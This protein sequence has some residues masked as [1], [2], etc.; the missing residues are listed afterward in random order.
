V[1]EP[2]STPDSTPSPL[3]PS[4]S[5]TYT[6]IQEEPSSFTDDRVE[7]IRGLEPGEV[8]GFLTVPK[9]DIW[10][11]P[12]RFGVGMANL[13]RG[14]S[15]YPGAAEPG[16]G[17][18][19]I[20]GHR[21]TPVGPWRTCSTGEWGSEDCHGPFRYLD[22]LE[23]GDTARVIYKGKTYHYEYADT[24][25]VDPSNISI[26]KDHRADMTFTACH[27]PGYSTKRIVAQWELVDG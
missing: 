16:E 10:R 26:L 27:P 22:T 1:F 25:I 5:V 3:K 6:V 14:P 9:L 4:S 18:F 24:L 7:R 2:D 12:I 20:A 17:N 21:I 19:S 8:V 23:P 15:L 13:D 11:Y